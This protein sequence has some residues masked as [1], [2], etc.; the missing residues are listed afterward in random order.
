MAAQ[1][2]I[3]TADLK[4]YLL[5]SGA[6]YDTYLAKVIS[7]VSKAI[8]SKTKRELKERSSIEEYLD[9]GGSNLLMPAQY[10]IT[11]IASIYVDNDRGFAASSLVSTT[12][13][14][15][16]QSKISIRGLGGYLWP[17]GIQNV[18]LTYT[19]GYSTIPEDIELACLL[20]CQDIW[21]K[22]KIGDGDDRL[23]KASETTDQ[24]GTL[25]F[26]VGEIPKEAAG[27]IKPYTRRRI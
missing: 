25:A 18:K 9:G 14:V 15:I 17:R 5:L 3:T 23:G 13:Y 12:D 26:V 6:S 16:D 1:D 8:E 2:L 10:P 22:G 4:E 27:L 11:A 21:H 24:G 19:Y 20:W 7:R